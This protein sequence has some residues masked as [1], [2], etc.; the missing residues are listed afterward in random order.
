MIANSEG[1]GERLSP[2]ALDEIRDQ[3]NSGLPLRALASRWN[4]SVGSL[5]QQLTEHR[6]RRDRASDRLA[7]TQ[8]LQRR[9]QARQRG[10]LPGGE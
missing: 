3:W 6:K 7:I 8:E 1:D 4:V 5:Q 9:I 10:R 2:A